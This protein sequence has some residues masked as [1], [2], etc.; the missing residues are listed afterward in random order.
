[1]KFSEAQFRQ[2]ENDFNGICLSCHGE[3]YGGIEGDAEN[4]ECDFC[5]E[6][7]VMGMHWLLFGGHI[8][9]TNEA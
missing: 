8:E 1:M 3:H 2:W 9:V 7:K 5:G 6:N 4:Y